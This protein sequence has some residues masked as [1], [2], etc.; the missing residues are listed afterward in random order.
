MLSEK[1]AI[2]CDSVKDLWQARVKLFALGVPH[3]MPI[4]DQQGGMSMSMISLAGM[5]LAVETT[6]HASAFRTIFAFCCA[7]LCVSLS[8]VA[9]GIDLSAGLI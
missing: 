9:L 1:S 5:P 8:L 4:Q 6:S 7:G 3:L 2:D